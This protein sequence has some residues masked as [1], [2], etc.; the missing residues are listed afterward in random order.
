[1]NCRQ[2][3]FLFFEHIGYKCTSWSK[4]RFV[5]NRVGTLT[6]REPC[7]MA[8]IFGIQKVINFL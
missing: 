4:V 5:P 1:M 7:L 8:N 3:T 6:M 2:Q